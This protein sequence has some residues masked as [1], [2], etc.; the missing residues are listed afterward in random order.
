LPTTVATNFAQHIEAVL[1]A[2]HFPGADRVY[3]DAKARDLVIGGKLR[4]ARGK[5]LRAI[6]HAA[7]TIGLLEF[8]R[9]NSTAHPGFVILDSPLLAYREPEGDDVDL[10]GTDLNAQF[11]Q[12]LTRLPDDR[13]VIVIENKDPP[14]E[15][16]ARPNVTMFS[17]NP[18]S[19]RYGFF[20]LSPDLLTEEAT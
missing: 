6:T 4:T 16:T 17:K 7:F 12:Y 5:G 19:G 13:Q 11:Y 10:L 2:W 3:F 15:I 1:K 14:T 18:H 9:A 8:C 20:P